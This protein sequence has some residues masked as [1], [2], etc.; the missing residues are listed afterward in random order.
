MKA[1][2]YSGEISALLFHEYNDGCIQDMLLLALAEMQAV[3]QVDAIARM[4]DKKN[5]QDP[6]VPETALFVLARL[7]AGQCDE[8]IAGLLNDSF[9]GGDA[10]LTLAL[11]GKTE[12]ASEIARLLKSREPLIRK[13]AA[14]ALG[15]LGAKADAHEI[16]AL[17][18]DDKPYVRVYAAASLLLLDAKEYSSGVLQQLSKSNVLEK[19]FKWNSLFASEADRYKSIASERLRQW[20]KEAQEKR[21][22]G[23]PVQ[24]QPSK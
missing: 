10:A 24:S 14:I 2:E 12:Y 15:V 20:T 21:Q 13:D 18:K 5:I 16:A 1:K 3:D 22:D 7:H 4:L 11:M 17:L 6:V 19:A 9:Y 23:K 8:K